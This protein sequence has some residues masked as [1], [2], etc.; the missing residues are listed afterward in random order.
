MSAVPPDC[1]PDHPGCEHSPQIL[2]GG[3][4][5]AE[6]RGAGKR[7]LALALVLIVGYMF[8]E[9]VGGLLSGSLALIADAGH[10]LT[11]AASI[12]LALAA[13]HFATRAASTRRTFGYHRLEILAAL[14]NGL[15]LVGI[16][17][18]VIVEAYQRFLDPPTVQG[19]LVLGV[20]SVGLLVNVAA[21]WIL[22]GS[23]KHSVNVEGAL[24]HVI[25]DLLGSVAVVVSGVLVWAFGWHLADPILSAFI[26]V[27]ILVGSW[28]L[29]ARVVHVLLEGTPDHVDIETLCTR[30]RDVEGVTDVHDVHCWTLAPGYE[31]LTAHVT[32]DPGRAREIAGDTVLDRLRHIAYHEFKLNHVTLQLEDTADR[33]NE[34]HHVDTLRAASRT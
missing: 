8:V 16:S 34:D 22:H 26:G 14:V 20:G 28:R 25:A 29:L 17:I 24:Q 7:S 30:M 1:A 5:S 10:M 6:L 12:G 21:A 3:D 27:L 19:G 33:C 18:W 13:M 9:V 15:T 31:A 4:H 11:D 2:R 32:V 23:A